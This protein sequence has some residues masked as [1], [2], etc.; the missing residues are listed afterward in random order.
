ML[1]LGV[2]RH[3]IRHRKSMRILLPTDGSRHAIAASRALGGW[4]EWPG[5]EVDVLAVSPARPKSDHRDFGR[6]TETEQDWRGTVSR[7][8]TDTANHLRASGLRSHELVRDGDPAD[9]AVEVAGDGYDLVAFGAKGR[10]DA[11]F[12]GPESVALALLERAPTSVLL[13]R[14]RA[15][16]GVDHRLPTPQHPLRVLL[17]V[18]GRRPTEAAVKVV[19]TLFA[20]GRAEVE[21][22][23]VADAGYRGGLGE[24]EATKV[25][26]RVATM[27]A[28]RGVAAEPRTVVGE[29]VSAI[30]DAAAGADLI[31]LGSRAEIGPG[32]TRVGGVGLTVAASSPCSVLVVRDAVSHA[33]GEIEEAPEVSIPFEIAYE[34]L[35][36]F[37]A[38]ERHVLRGL[39]RLER[40]APNLVRVRVTLA[41]RGAR[42]QTGDLYTVSLEVTG[43]GPDVFVSRT[44]ALHSESEDLLTAIG[45]AFDKARRG[46][47]ESRAVTRGDVKSHEPVAEGTVTALFPDYGF[48]HAKDGRVV[49]FHRHSVLADAWDDMEV[50]AQV[51][52]VDEPGDEGPQATTV[53]VQSPSRAPVS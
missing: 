9:V 48:I 2:T 19:G 3:P 44:P 15:R 51:R 39:A 14:D 38:A 25:A 27:L 7:W 35:E 8:L 21:V 36:P 30:L 4:F 22:L 26:K 33:I 47:V 41:R 53:V 17:A 49:Y 24:A 13:V 52:F 11:P 42:R 29:A 40:L 32:E 16:Y 20:P 31:V 1:V 10:G 5:G 45:E 6:D 23:A 28:G 12:F 50:G 43:P 37:P 18:D 34:N 46:L